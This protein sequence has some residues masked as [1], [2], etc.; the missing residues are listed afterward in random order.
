ME[1]RTEGVFGLGTGMFGLVDL[2]GFLAS[3]FGK[4]GGDGELILTG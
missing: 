4:M 2:G 3:D 1:A